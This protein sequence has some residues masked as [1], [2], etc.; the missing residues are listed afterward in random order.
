MT[1]IL[2]SLPGPRSHDAIVFAIFTQILFCF[3]WKEFEKVGDDV[4]WVKDQ[5]EKLQ[6]FNDCQSD[7]D[8]QIADDAVKCGIEVAEY[9]SIK[10]AAMQDLQQPHSQLLTININIFFQIFIT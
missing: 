4:I 2:G 8:R 3:A 7:K 1:W 9:Y 5:P 10:A 6:L